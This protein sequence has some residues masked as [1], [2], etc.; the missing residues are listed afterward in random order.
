MCYATLGGDYEDGAWDCSGAPQLKREG[1][2]TCSCQSDT[3]ERRGQRTIAKLE[4]QF[5][6]STRLKAEIR[7][8]LKG[9]GYEI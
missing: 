6:E 9:L 1:T 2:A 3:S 4:K 7:A 8:N 5:R